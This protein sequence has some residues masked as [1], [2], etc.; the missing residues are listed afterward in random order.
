[1]KTKKLKAMLWGLTAIFTP[2][3]LFANQPEPWQINFQKP[4]TP[5]MEQIYDLH[6]LVMIIITLIALFVF[7][8]MGFII[9]RF[10]AKRNPHPSKRSHH[11]LLEFIWTA[12]PVVILLIIAIPSFKLMFYMDKA[13]D[14]GLTVKVTGHTWYWEYEYP[15]HEISFD[16]NIIPDDQ[17]QPG[18]LRLL[19]VDNH[20]VVPVNTNVRLL[21]TAA[22]VIHSWA[23]PSF[24]LKK[25][26]VPG[27]LNETWIHVNKEGIYYGQCS[28][29]C[30]MKHGFM[31]IVV[32]VISQEEFQQWLSTAKQKF[33]N[34]DGRQ[35]RQKYLV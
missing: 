5:V 8:I 29:L 17:L 34:L 10:R 14:P 27:R 20:I 21:F 18:Q 24:G 11:T 19:E 7:L 4:A 12:L 23:V 2:S 22:D 3:L 26:C 28:E 33:A 31:P 1:M 13:K 32:R 9:F 30:G 35:F 15:E 16:S 6:N 25:D